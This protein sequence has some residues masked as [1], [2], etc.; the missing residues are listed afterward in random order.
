[1]TPVQLQRAFRAVLGLSPRD[2]VVACRRERFLKQVKSGG[3]VTDA[4]YASGFGSPSRVYDA[5]RL[6][7]MTPATYGR[8]GKGAHIRWMSG[9]TPIGHVMVA[10]TDRGL[11]FVQVG[12]PV[13]MLRSL[14]DEFPLAMIDARASRALQPLLAAA[15]AVAT[16]KPLPAE[17]PIDIRGTAFQWRVWR[18]LTKIPRGETRSYTDIAKAIGSPSSVRAVARACATNPVALVVPCHRVVR[19]DGDLAGYRWGLKVK[20]TLL[21]KE[22]H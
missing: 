15:Q 9:A 18:A 2:Y 13:T 11:C 12:E 21:S 14:R 5:I 3:R 19:A 22:Q 7:G 4:I 1:T 10:S 20:K 16:A 6:P 8:G 17:L